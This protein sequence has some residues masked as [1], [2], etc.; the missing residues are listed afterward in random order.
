ML[1]IIPGILTEDIEELKEG[2]GRVEGFAQRVHVDII[3]GI[4]VDRRTL[5]LESLEQVEIGPLLD[6]HLMMRT[7]EDWVEHVARSMAD[8]VIGHI[9]QMGSQKEFVVG[10]CEAGMGVGLAVDI[11]TELGRIDSDLI[12]ELDVILV[13]GVR[14]GWSGQEFDKRALA[15]VGWLTEK[16]DKEGLGFSICIDGGVNLENIGKIKDVGADEVVVTSYLF[17]GDVED[18][19][20]SL[21]DLV[22]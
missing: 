22:G 16:R 13:M 21:R 19:W 18:N 11:D 10:V 9:E 4:F 20:K 12:P 6:L 8:R 15:K 2:I 3:D 7:P 17:G 14:A 1:E 5:S